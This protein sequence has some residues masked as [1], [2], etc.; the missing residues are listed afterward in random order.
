MSCSMIVKRWLAKCS[1]DGMV[2]KPT[3][4]LLLH[5]YE[6]YCY[7]LMEFASCEPYFTG[8]VEAIYEMKESYMFTMYAYDYLDDPTTKET[9]SVGYLYPNDAMTQ[10]IINFGITLRHNRDCL[11]IERYKKKKV[12][13]IN[14]FDKQVLT[15]RS[16]YYYNDQDFEFSSILNKLMRNFIALRRKF[17]RDIFNH[18][19]KK[20]H[21]IKIHDF[22][23]FKLCGSKSK[24]F[25]G[26]DFKFRNWI[27]DVQQV[28]D[29]VDHHIYKLNFDSNFILKRLLDIH[30]PTTNVITIINNNQVKRC[31]SKIFN[32]GYDS[33]HYP[34]L[35]C[36]FLSHRENPGYSN[37]YDDMMQCY[38]LLNILEFIFSELDMSLLTMDYI[39]GKRMFAKAIRCK[40]NLS[41]KE[42]FDA[43]NNHDCF[44]NRMDDNIDV[45]E[46]LDSHGINLDDQ[47]NSDQD[48]EDFELDQDP[49]QHISLDDDEESEY[50]NGN[51]YS[52]APPDIRARALELVEQDNELDLMDATNIAYAEAQHYA[53]TD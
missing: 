21:I 45:H 6:H 12:R 42:C 13:I 15:E 16:L 38:I 35:E 47:S 17:S 2:S 1:A 49:I 8:I 48:S 9:P 3:N 51:L 31:S 50:H 46:A 7:D 19:K 41:Y 44:L 11:V 10:N 23:T 18:L 43:H 25:S 22:L 36:H 52:N 28:R 24:D 34:I 40:H 39:P 37:S 32:C 30:Y 4:T 53:E 29:S 33:I 5:L 26:S 20:N 27:I 14:S